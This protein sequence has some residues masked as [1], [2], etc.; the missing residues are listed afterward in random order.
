MA[1]LLLP[2][3]GGPA[4]KKEKP[5]AAAPKP[6]VLSAPIALFTP[7]PPPADPNRENRFA[8]VMR[9]LSTL[10]KPYRFGEEGPSRFD[11]S[12]LVLYSY[13]Q[14]GVS[15]PR[16]AREQ[17]RASREIAVQDLKPG[18]LVFF[19]IRGGKITDHVGIYVGERSFIHAPS[20]GSTVRKANLDD[21]YWR[22][23]FVRAGRF[24]E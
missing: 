20:A 3:C 14:T 8:V 16:T 17:L 11:C 10:G 19:R 13:G 2:G 7:D 4:V 12:G 21:R 22:K 15:V 1:A 23:R 18:D 24:L 9:A 5:L 6:L